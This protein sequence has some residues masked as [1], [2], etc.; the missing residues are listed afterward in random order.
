MRLPSR[1]SLID[2]DHLFLYEHDCRE[3]HNPVSSDFTRLMYVTRFELVLRMIDQWALGI[4]VLDV[5]CAQ[6]NF[7]LALA[8]RDYRVVAMD[9]RRSFLHYLRMKHERGAVSCIAATVER[10]PFVAG[11]FDVVLLAEVIEHVAYPER[12]LRAATALLAPGGILVLTT[13]NGSRVR[14]GL[15]TL[16]AVRD[17]ESLVPRQFQ[18]DADGHLFLLTPD[19]LG[20]LARDAGLTVKAHLFFCTP[21]V[22]GRLRARHV[23]WLLPVGARA[24]LDRLTHRLGGLNRFVSE[25]QLVVAVRAGAGGRG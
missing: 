10:F 17:R 20:K 12:L 13:P 22:S 5:G 24:W 25:G 21:W 23:A 9:L 16:A 4:R 3:L 15:P 19:E 1:E 11:A 6:G 18:P 2:S 14:T 8:E 7:S